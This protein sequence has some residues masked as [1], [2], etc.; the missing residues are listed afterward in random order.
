MANAP[1]G[2]A[3][4]RAR[5]FLPAIALGLLSSAWGA[6]CLGEYRANHLDL[7]RFGPCEEVFEAL[8]R[9]G[10]V[11]GFLLPYFTAATLLDGLAVGALVVAVAAGKFRVLEVLVAVLCVPTVAW[12]ALG[13]YTLLLTFPPADF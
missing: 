7:S 11:K 1:E 6:S 10:Y 5:P 13:L 8:A 4:H 9:D 2:P 3:T 12:H